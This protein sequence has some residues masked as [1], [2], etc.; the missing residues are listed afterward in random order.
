MRIIIAD[1]HP[2]VR[3][4]VKETLGRSDLVEVI[5]EAQD[6][7]E[8]LAMVQQH[9]PDLLI[10]D[11][12]MP[13]CPPDELAHEVCEAHP[14]LKVLV[15]SG[16]NDPHF[17]RKLVQVKLS[18]YLLKDEAP[19]NLLQAVRTIGQ[20]ASWFSQAVAQKLMSLTTEPAENV[21]ERLTPREREIMQQ[22][23]DGKDNITIS[24]ELCLSE[25]TV[26]NY[27]SLIYQKI[28]V[29]SRVEAVLLAHK[30]AAVQA[31]AC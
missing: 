5:G 11:L 3:W 10:L 12:D 25:Q 30:Q 17:L 21:F 1:D 20:G 29:K 6:T 13:G 31:A 14:E 9:K 27:T 26:R 23:S 15:L 22:M 16:R 19:E 2:L 7:A 8:T 18:G 4:G 28:G 24:R